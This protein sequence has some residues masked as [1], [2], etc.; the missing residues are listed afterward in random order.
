MELSAA[1]NWTGEFR[2]L[3]IADKSDPTREYLYTIREV[4][5]S[6]GSIELDDKKYDVIYTGDMV[7][8]FTITN[9]EIPPEEPPEEPPETPEEPPETPEV[10]P[11]TPEEPPETPPV[12]PPK[13]PKTP[14]KKPGSPQTG[15]DGVSGAFA[16]MSSAAA[17]L[18]V[19]QR[20]KKE[21]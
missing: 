18:F 11:E 8:G 7:S 4:G 19:L 10:P 16:L 12:I 2:D 15:V 3:E 20:K 6:N 21:D 1:N 17:G 9:K 14:P 5:E 13:T